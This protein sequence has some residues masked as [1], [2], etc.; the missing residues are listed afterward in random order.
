VDVR[1]TPRRLAARFQWVQIVLFG[2]LLLAPVLDNLLGLDPT[3]PR[4]ELRVAAARPTLEDLEDLEDLPAALR[5]WVRDHFGFRHGLIRLYALLAVKGL[6]VTSSDKVVLGRDGWAYFAD[7]GAIESYRAVDPFD[8]AELAH[9][10]FV[11][12]ARRRWL[13]ER[14]IAYLVAIAPNKHTIHPEHLPAQITRVGRESRLDQLLAA[15]AARSSVEAVDLRPPLRAAARERNVYDPLGTHWNELGAYLAYAAI[16]AHASE[17]L[18]GIHALGLDAFEVD[19]EPG[20]DVALARM[21][22]LEGVLEATTLRLAPRAGWHVRAPA[23]PARRCD[24]VTV[25]PEDEGPHV[26]VIHDSFGLQLQPFVSETFARAC[27][28]GSEWIKIVEA[29]RDAIAAEAPDLVIHLFAERRLERS[30]LGVPPW[31]VPRPT[32]A[33]D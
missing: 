5:A 29:Q 24:L 25:L 2:A 12:E 22:G 9:L 1:S 32:S 7:E 33:L 30:P 6:G 14:G 13:A 3:P 21:L 18:P 10:V 31:G 16:L 26:V 27:F 17:S 20:G 11:F 28:L 15:L 23:R 19:E 4:R 8:A